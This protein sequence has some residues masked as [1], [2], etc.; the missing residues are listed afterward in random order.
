MELIDVP[1]ENRFERP[2]TPVIQ[3]PQIRR[4]RFPGIAETVGV[5]G[6]LL[7]RGCD[8]NRPDAEV[9]KSTYFNEIEP[10]FDVWL[11]LD[12]RN[13]TVEMWREIGLTCLQVANGNF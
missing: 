2:A 11:V 5:E 4:T 7:M 1:H 6:R 13:Q 12:D 8:D 9:K 10:G 3:H